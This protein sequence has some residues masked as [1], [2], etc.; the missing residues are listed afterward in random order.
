MARA[1]GGHGALLAWA[2][3]RLSDGGCVLLWVTVDV[4]REL[5]EQPGWRVLS[6]PLPGMERG[7]LVQMVP[8]FT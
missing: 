3:N 6:S 4:E 7:R 1:L 2:R 5:E 8:C